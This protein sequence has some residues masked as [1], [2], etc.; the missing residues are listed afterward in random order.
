[1]RWKKAPYCWNAKGSLYDKYY[2]LVGKT[3]DAGE[4]IWRNDLLW[5]FASD[6]KVDLMVT[7]QTVPGLLNAEGKLRKW[8]PRQTEAQR[9]LEG[10][11]RIQTPHYHY[12]SSNYL[13]S[14][15]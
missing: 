11:A 6:H 7:R 9:D 15:A 5:K 12:E 13:Q 10:R 14:P 4:Y 3:D 2:Y 1:M 8:A